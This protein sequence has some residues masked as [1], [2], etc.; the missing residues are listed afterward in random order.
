MKRK[1]ETNPKQ[2]MQYWT[3]QIQMKLLQL[4]QTYLDENQ[5]TRTE[6]AEKLGVTKGYVSQVMAGDYDHRI[7]KMVELTMTIGY[8]PQIEFIPAETVFSE[9]EAFD[10]KPTKAEK[11]DISKNTVMFPK[12]VDLDAGTTSTYNTYPI[13]TILAS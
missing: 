8:I 13:N 3:T 7:S 5:M 9:S 12:P 4:I 10:L 2:H 6:L 1:N 11:S